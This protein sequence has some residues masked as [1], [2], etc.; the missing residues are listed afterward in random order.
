MTRYW[1]TSAPLPGHLDWGG[2]IKTA[3]VLQARGHDVLWVSEAPIAPLVERAGIPFAAVPESGWN[4]PP[5]P[6]PD[7][8]SLPPREAITLRYRRALDTWMKEDRVLP[9]VEAMRDLADRTGPPDV[10]VT[11][12]F[13][14]A[15]ALLAELLD[16]PLVVGGWPAGPPIDEDHLLYVQRELGR[17]GAARVE[18][19]CAHFGLHGINFGGGAA[20][21]M[22]SPLL[23]ISYFS[24]YWHQGELFLPQTQ[25]VGGIVT[26]PSG[27]PPS[28]LT[29]I[30]V[31]LPL[32]LVTLGTVFTGDLDF[33]AWG[34][35]ALAANGIV[36]LVVI[37]N[38]PL[39]S[40]A[41]AALIR[42]AA[43]RNA[44]SGLG[45]F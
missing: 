21:S 6:L 41:K 36:P 24:P 45:R 33:F 19:L 39:D 13:L 40:E 32:G 27:D 31:D 20:P 38:N 12:P 7:P 17:D 29:E 34:A 23:H 28:W 14:I 11:D 30:P 5:P 16:V 8:R 18:R 26:A 3:Q 15:S 37:G 22:Q 35:H 1:F 2:L 44:P 25:F 42:K 43:C 4:W 10:I 9:A